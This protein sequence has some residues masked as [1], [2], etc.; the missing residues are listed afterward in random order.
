MSPTQHLVEYSQR[1]VVK[2]TTWAKNVSLPFLDGVPVYNVSVF[3]GGVL[4]MDPLQQGL[5]R[6][7]STS[8]LPCSRL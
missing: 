4:S 7:L 8:L 6:L 3:F 5:R 1:Y 2:L